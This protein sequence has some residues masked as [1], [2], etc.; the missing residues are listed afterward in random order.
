MDF[1]TNALCKTPLVAQ[2][3][4][5]KSNI[6]ISFSV[7]SIFPEAHAYR[8]RWGFTKIT[9]KDEK[10]EFCFCKKIKMSQELHK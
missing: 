9:C 7:F 2:D 10:Y 6:M 1:A 8:L 4:L 3:T 5:S